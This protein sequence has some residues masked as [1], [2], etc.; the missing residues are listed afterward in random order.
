MPKCFIHLEGLERVNPVAEKGKG[1]GESKYNETE[2]EAVVS[3]HL[4]SNSHVFLFM[5]NSI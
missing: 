1:G 3:V 4:R 5:V 2:V